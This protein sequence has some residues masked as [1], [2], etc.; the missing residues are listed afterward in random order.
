MEAF[1]RLMLTAELGKGNYVVT[2]DLY[3]V[4]RAAEQ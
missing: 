4:A 1:Y 2:Q 3:C